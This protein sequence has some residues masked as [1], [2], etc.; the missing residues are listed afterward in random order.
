MAQADTAFKAFMAK[1]YQKV[2][3]IYEYMD[4]A[5]SSVNGQPCF[6]SARILSRSDWDKVRP[7]ISR[8]LERR[9]QGPEI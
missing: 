9:E 2:G 7:V 6:L 5:V 8:E 4:R 1:K 3:V